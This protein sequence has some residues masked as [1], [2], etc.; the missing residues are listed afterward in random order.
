[1]TCNSYRLLLNATSANTATIA[2][3]E[4]IANARHVTPGAN[5]TEAPRRREAGMALPLHPR[6]RRALTIAVPGGGLFRA[7]DTPNNN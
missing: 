7:K 6:T 3:Y 2:L 5:D 4:R 1:M